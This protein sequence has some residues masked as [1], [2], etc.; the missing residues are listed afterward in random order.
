MTLEGNQPLMS[1]YTRE[2]LLGYIEQLKEAGFYD[3][4]HLDLGWEAGCPLKADAEKFPNGISEIARLAKSAAG[5]DMAF[6]VNPFSASYWKS[7]IE[8]EHPEYLVPNKVSGRSGASAICIMTDYFNYVKQRF[9]ELVSESNARVI[10]WDGADWNIPVCTAK[11]HDHLDQGELEVNAWKRLAELC[12][13]AHE[14]RKDLI[15]INFSLPFNNHRLC[16]VDCEQVSDTYSFPTIQSE[17]IQ[18]QQIYQMAFEHPYKAI[19]G[20]WYGVNWHFAGNDNLTKR[21][22]KELIHAEMSMIGNGLAQAGG[23]LDL[24]QAKPEFIDFLKRLFAFRKRFEN[25]FGVYQH[26]LGF[27]DGKHPDGSGHIV[28]GSGFIVLVNPTQSEQTVKLPLGEPG[29]ELS[30]TQ[31]HELTDWTNLDYTIPIGSYKTKDAPEIDLLPLDVRYI[32]VN[33]T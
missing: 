25:Y 16:A 28:D 10:F 32:G 5:L 19:W 15:V 9:S 27:P 18:R 31:K 12:E 17:L 8:E 22:F 33:I 3:V 26:V 23:S 4:L 7:R 14:A 13:T 30:E 1:N 20:S 29:L 24:K 11:N 21:P 6:W 2:L